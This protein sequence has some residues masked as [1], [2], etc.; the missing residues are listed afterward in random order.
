MNQDERNAN[1]A[2]LAKLQALKEVAE[3]L[4]SKGEKSHGLVMVETTET[5]KGLETKNR[6]MVDGDMRQVL[7]LIGGSLKIASEL[8]G[9]LP[10]DFIEYAKESRKE[11]LFTLFMQSA[12]IG[13]ELMKWC[14]IGEEQK[15]G[16]Q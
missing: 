15:G 14:G 16:K 6:I 5:E 12:E 2:D 7:L 8:I 3:Y 11:Q 4:K 1:V 13:S 9:N 10:D